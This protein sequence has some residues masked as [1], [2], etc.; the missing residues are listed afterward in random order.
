MTGRCCWWDRANTQRSLT[1]SDDGLTL[2]W[3]EPS[4]AMRLSVQTTGR[5]NGICSGSL[6]IE[7][8]AQKANRVGAMLDPQTGASADILGLGTMRGLRC[9][10]EAIVAETDDLHRGLPTL[11][12]RGTV[13]VSV[14]L[15]DTMTL[16]FT[17]NGVKTPAIPIRPAQ[18]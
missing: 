15:V 4:K 16:T 7:S 3:K 8:I 1:I 13:A 12:E 11:E 5:L 17:V 18:R 2:S 6:T 10:M 14:D 9:T